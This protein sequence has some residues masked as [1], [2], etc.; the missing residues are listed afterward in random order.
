MASLIGLNRA[1]PPWL[2]DA[3]GIVG[4]VAL[5]CLFAANLLGGD[6]TAPLAWWALILLTLTL[7]GGLTV[8]ALFFAVGYR[9]GLHCFTAHWESR[10]C[11]YC[12]WRYGIDDA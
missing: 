2:G 8:F 1:Y 11:T 7:V 3:H 5:A 6:R 10:A 4:L 12:F 9:S